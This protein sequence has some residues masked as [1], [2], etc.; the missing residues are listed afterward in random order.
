M[1][2]LNQMYGIPDNLFLHI[3]HLHVGNSTLNQR[4]GREYVTV[5]HIVDEYDKVTTARAVCSPRDMPSRKMG[6]DIAI[7]RVWKKY[8]GTS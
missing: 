5:A 6:R 8:N 4:L 3:Q 2:N 7:G 1:S